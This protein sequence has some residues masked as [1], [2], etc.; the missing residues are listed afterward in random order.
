MK[1]I[2]IIVL[3]AVACVTAAMAKGKE[4]VA[5]SDVPVKAKNAFLKIYTDND[6]LLSTKEKKV[7]RKD[8]TFIL[9]D[10]TKITYDDKGVLREV[11][12]TF[13]VRDTL[14]PGAI[15]KYVAKTLPNATVTKYFYERS[16]QEVVMNDQMKLVFDR[17]GKFLRLED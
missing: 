9:V 5:F 15:V 13:G 3:L 14:L 8:Y 2:A 10:D 11:Q 16:K 17:K 6:V 1:R 7:G 12:N 4:P